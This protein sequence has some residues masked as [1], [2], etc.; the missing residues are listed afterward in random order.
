LALGHPIDV[1]EAELSGSDNRIVPNL[2]DLHRIT[3]RVAVHV[4]AMCLA[5]K[6]DGIVR[7]IRISSV[8]RDVRLSLHISNNLPKMPDNMLHCWDNAVRVGQRPSS[9]RT[10]LVGRSVVEC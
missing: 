6:V 3:G 7:I 4:H 5:S 2:V 9:L 8:W 1:V 10:E